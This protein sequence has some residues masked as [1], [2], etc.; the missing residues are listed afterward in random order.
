MRMRP[1]QVALGAVLALAI[2]LAGVPFV[3]R[4][5]E[6]AALR[7]VVVDSRGFGIADASVFL[8]QES[9]LRL[10][11][12][13]RSDEDGDFEFPLM[14]QDAR[15]FVQPSPS[16]GLLASWSP[17]RTEAE[18]RVAF[19]LHPAR[20]LEVRVRDAQGAPVPLAEVRVYETRAEPVVVALGRTDGTGLARM[21]APPRAHVAVLATQEPRLMRWR[22]EQDIP[23]RGARLEFELPAPRVL[24]GFVRS[25]D[26]PLAG[27]VLVAWEEGDPE[28]WNGFAHSDDSGRF[29]L[30]STRT[31]TIVRALDPS[32]AHLP[33]LL[34]VGPETGEPLDLELQPGSPQVV[35]TTRNGF[36]LEAMVW[37]W[38][39]TAETWSFGARTSKGGRATLPVGERFS[40]LAEP[41]DPAFAPMEAWDVPY[42]TE[43]LHLEALPRR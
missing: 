43:T 40:I 12:E 18:E 6:E 31:R 23:A 3:L 2:S 42:R 20:T 11:G 8:F 9:E 26:G 13:T 29:E 28:G 15:I 24:R 22:F 30:P 33:A 14:P 5:P 35:R 10:V 36:P 37:S 4:S 19:V 1:T 21:P 41:L 25:P 27:I 16:S 38:S 39:P 34:H 32:G 17:S 7:G